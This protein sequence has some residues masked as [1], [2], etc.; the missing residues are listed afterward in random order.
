MPNRTM[1]QATKVQSQASQ[2]KIKYGNVNPG[3]LG[4]KPAF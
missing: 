2:N 1:Y 4:H 3:G